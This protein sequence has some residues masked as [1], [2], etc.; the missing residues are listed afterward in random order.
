MAKKYKNFGELQKITI[1]ENKE[2][3]REAKKITMHILNK[4]SERIQ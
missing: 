3:E 2:R 1:V 4:I